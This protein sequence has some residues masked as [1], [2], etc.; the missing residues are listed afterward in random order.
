MGA[1]K[2]T[3]SKEE[4]EL[5]LNPGWILTK[6]ALIGKVYDLFGGL[7]D[8]YREI[9]PVTHPVFI[10]ETAVLSPKISKGEQYKGLPWVML[11]YPRQFGKMDMFAIRSFFWWGKYASIS[12]LLQGNFRNR[13]E[14]SVIE[15]LLAEKD[16]PNETGEWLIPDGDQ[17]WEHD[18]RATG[19]AS[20]Q[21]WEGQFA[22]EKPCIKI[23]A[24]WPL[25]QWDVLP[26]FFERKFREL[27]G[28]ID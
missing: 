25:Q 13:M 27:A 18:I 19:Y 17:P 4:Q 10:G 7:S 15:Y 20:L 2:I 24:T 21:Q 6:N 3:L 11:D 8:V 23:T 5:L 14:K 22:P 1:T 26:A 16:K 12:L 9:L 28:C